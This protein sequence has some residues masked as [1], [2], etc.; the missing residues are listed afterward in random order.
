MLFLAVP[1]SGATAIICDNVP[2][3]GRKP[4][5]TSTSPLFAEIKKYSAAIK[6][7]PPTTSI[8][9]RCFLLIKNL[10]SGSN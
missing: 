2:I 8:T 5:S 1:E 6:T 4:L 10:S 7:A 3:T 9:I